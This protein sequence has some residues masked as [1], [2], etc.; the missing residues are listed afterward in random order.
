MEKRST[1]FKK[2]EKNL[3]DLEKFKAEY[4]ILKNKFIKL[5]VFGNETKK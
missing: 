5:S 2:I 3:T 4:L 1:L